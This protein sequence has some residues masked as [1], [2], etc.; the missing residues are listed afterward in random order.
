MCC[1]GITEVQTG[2]LIIIIIIINFL[3]FFQLQGH[4]CYM[5][6]WCPQQKSRNKVSPGRANRGDT[7][8]NIGTN[9]VWHTNNS[10][11]ITSTGLGWTSCCRWEGKG[12]AGEVG[13]SRIPRG[14]TLLLVK[15]Y[16]SSEHTHSHATVAYKTWCRHDGPNYDSPRQLQRIRGW[17]HCWARSWVLERPHE[18]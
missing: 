13:G 16:T 1:L 9:S 12:T 17:F 18:Q 7:T 11:L 8:S 10:Q 6:S 5:G 4:W 2:L 15:L 3:L 14:S